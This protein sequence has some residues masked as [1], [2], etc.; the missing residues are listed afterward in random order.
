MAVQT[1]SGA[2]ENTHCLEF[3]HIGDCTRWLRDHSANTSTIVLYMNKTN[4]GFVHTEEEIMY[5]NHFWSNY[6]NLYGVFESG[7]SSVNYIKYF[8]SQNHEIEDEIEE[9]A[10]SC[11]MYQSFS[12]GIL[13]SFIH[14]SSISLQFRVTQGLR[15]ARLSGCK[16]QQE[17][18]TC[19]FLIAGGKFIIQFVIKYLSVMLY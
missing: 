12:K 8:S 16:Q 13:E 5:M 2:K 9:T 18:N 19:R 7:N 3:E 11:C 17:K 6:D 15:A 14:R 1:K 4:C 10:D